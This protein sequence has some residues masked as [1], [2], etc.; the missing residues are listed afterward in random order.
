MSTLQIPDDILKQAG[1]TEREAM[2]QL[3]CRLFQTGRLTL[4]FAAQLA[5]MSQPGF[6]DILL[7]NNIPIY[8]Y[9]EDDLRS[10]LRTIRGVRP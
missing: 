9:T 10:D 4:F 2:V 7:D 3:A 8:E 6:E 5:G 1:I